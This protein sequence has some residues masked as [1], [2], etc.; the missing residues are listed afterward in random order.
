M[1]RTSVTHSA[2]AACATFL[3][4]SGS[5]AS[6]SRSVKPRARRVG[7]EQAPYESGK[8]QFGERSVNPA[9]KLVGVGA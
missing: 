7:C 1:V 8:K 9:A 4:E 5:E 2:I 3:C 6:G